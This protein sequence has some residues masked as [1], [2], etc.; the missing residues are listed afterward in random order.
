[1][2]EFIKFLKEN[3]ILAAIIATVIST[4]VSRIT[5]SFINDIV[6]P[7]INRDGDNDNKPD[8]Y[9]LKNYKIN[10]FGFEIKLGNFL[11]NLIK[12]LLV[13][14]LVFLVFLVKGSKKNYKLNWEK[15]RP[16]FIRK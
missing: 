7:I 16:G 1:M 12:F 11:V 4:Y 13:L 8:I 9:K 3:D 6:M 14:F 2:N 10:C 15:Y 5:E